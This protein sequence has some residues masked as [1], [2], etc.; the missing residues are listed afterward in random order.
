M[1]TI[2]PTDPFS[3]KGSHG[4]CIEEKRSERVSHS[5][6]CL[7]DYEENEV[8]PHVTYFER[9]IDL[10]SKLLEINGDEKDHVPESGLKLFVVED[11]S[12]D[13]IDLLGHHLRIEPDFFRSHLREH[14][15]FNIRDPFWVPPSLH[16]DVASRNWHQVFFCRARYFTDLAKFREAQRAVDNFNIKRKLDEDESKALWDRSYPTSKP[17]FPQLHTSIFRRRKK[18][19]E[20]HE[21][22]LHGDHKNISGEQGIPP[23]EIQTTNADQELIEEEVDAKVGLMRTKATFWWKNK[24]IGN[25]PLNH[26]MEEPSLINGLF[27]RFIIRP[28]PDGRVSAL[29]RTRELA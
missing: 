24:N 4:Y 15:W 21:R 13:T 25:H 6:V 18:R 26:V 11:L 7:L 9:P 14:A 5:R 1:Q 2:Y 10:R 22:N 12:R 29:E 3:L 20:I 17:I 8:E 19:N 23:D 27:R 16:M 28:N